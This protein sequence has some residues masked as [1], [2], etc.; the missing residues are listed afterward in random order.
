MPATKVALNDPFNGF[1]LAT[2]THVLSILVIIIKA[3]SH[4]H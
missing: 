2:S 1:K 3:T 4:K